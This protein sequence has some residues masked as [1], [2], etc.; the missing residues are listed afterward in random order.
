M[1]RIL[2]VAGKEFLHILRDRRSLAVALLMPLT[3]VLLYGAVIDMELRD[4][5]VGVLDLDGG[6]RSRELLRAMTSSGFIIEAERLD[7]RDAIEAGFRQGR[8]QAALVVPRGYGEDL[9]R[10]GARVQIL[11]DG[12]DASTAATVANYL[13]AVVALVNRDLLREA[14]LAA[15]FDARTRVWFNP[16]LVS[17]RFVVPGLVAL[18]LMMICALLTSIAITRE[19]EAGT[20]EQILT[21]PVTPAQVIVGKVLPYVAL[22]ALDC[23]MVLLAGKWVFGVPMAG[24]W[25]LL[26]AYCLLFIVIALSLGLLISARSPSLRVAMMAALMVTMLPTMI[27]SGFV[28]PIASMP[29]PLQVVCRLLPATH[30]LVVLRGIMLKGQAWFPLQTA[31]LVLMAAVLLTLAI[32]SFRLRLE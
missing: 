12:A 22:G 16:E 18:V 4:L 19:K 8:L 6:D 5:R 30:F 9:A 27:L 2:A 23:A 24:S 15:P 3:M 20:L 1:N 29:G 11:V 21:T 17:A 25:W 28:F 7:G 14:G 13:Q 26:A 10:G 31:A 32:R